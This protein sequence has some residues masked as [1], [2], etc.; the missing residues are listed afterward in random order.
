MAQVDHTVELI[1]E[2][3]NVRMRFEDLIRV[4]KYRARVAYWELM[5]TVEPTQCVPT[6]PPWGGAEES[7]PRPQ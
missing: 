1:N 6:P 2:L 3:K 7:R 4:Q 5:R